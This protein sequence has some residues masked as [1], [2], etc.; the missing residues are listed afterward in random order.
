[1]V[2]LP[3]DKAALWAAVTLSEAVAVVPEVAVTVPSVVLP[4]LKVTL[5]AIVPEVVEVTVADRLKPTPFTTEE[6][7]GV[8]VVVVVAAV[9]GLETVIAL[10]AEEL[11]KERSL[12]L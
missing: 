4:A 10:L 11:L 2:T 1:M 3:V 6:T 5:P 9:T 12:L 7:L 8:T